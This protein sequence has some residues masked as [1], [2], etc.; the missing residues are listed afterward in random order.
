MN[1]R[2]PF[3]YY[4]ILLLVLILSVVFWLGFFMYRPFIYR[5]IESSPQV[6]EPL[7]TDTTT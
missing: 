4:F 7:S 6:E 1:N 3:H 2:Y 5:S